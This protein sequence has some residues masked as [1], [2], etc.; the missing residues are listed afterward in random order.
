MVLTECRRHGDADQGDDGDGGEGWNHRCDRVS[1]VIP[2][3]LTPGIFTNA[4]Q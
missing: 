4:C 2:A 3:F 1:M